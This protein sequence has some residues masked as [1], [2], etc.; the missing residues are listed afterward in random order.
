M[1]VTRDVTRDVPLKTA[2]TFAVSHNYPSRP[3]PTR[4]TSSYQG[5]SFCLQDLLLQRHLGDR[6]SLERQRQVL[7]DE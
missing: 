3:V 4:P 6:A 1:S 7:R 2:V 5:L